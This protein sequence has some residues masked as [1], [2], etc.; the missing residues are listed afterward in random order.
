MQDGIIMDS[1]SFDS[2]SGVRYGCATEVSF[3]SFFVRY[4]EHGCGKFRT[5]RVSAGEVIGHTDR[6]FG[7]RSDVDM[8]HI[9]FYKG[10]ASGR[11]T[12]IGVGAYSRRSDLFNPTDILQNLYNDQK[13]DVNTK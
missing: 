1:Y 12:Q 9:E 2:A 6:L 8:L 10:T 7:V 11:L 3:P 13:K 4:S 5:G